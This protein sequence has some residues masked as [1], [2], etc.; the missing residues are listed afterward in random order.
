[1]VQLGPLSFRHALYADM[2]P[3]I[4]PGKGL[5]FFDESPAHLF[6]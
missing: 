5:G 3:A 4:L 6:I 1:M 2:A